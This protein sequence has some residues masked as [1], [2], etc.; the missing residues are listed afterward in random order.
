MLLIILGIF[1]MM[2]LFLAI[3]LNNFSDI[4]EKTEE[5]RA[6]ARPA[7]ARRGP[8]PDSAARGRLRCA[9]AGLTRLL[10]SPAAPAA[11]RWRRWEQI[12]VR[13]GCIQ[14]SSTS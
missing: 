7:A 3:L 10:R 1:L 8:A 12:E 13:E 9:A 11:G 14:P 6:A 2:N 4:N 5:A